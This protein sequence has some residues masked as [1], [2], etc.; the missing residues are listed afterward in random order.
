ATGVVVHFP[1]P[2]GTVYTGGNEWTA[3][4]GSFNPFGN[5][6]WTVGNVPAGDTASITVSYFLLQNNLPDAYAQVIAANETDADSTPGNGTPPSVNEDD[7]ASSLSAPPM[8]LPD[9]RLVNLNIQ[10]SP[11]AQGSILSYSFD[12]GNIGDAPVSGHFN[13]KAWIST[14]TDI[15]PDDVPGEIISTNN[16]PAGHIVTGIAGASAV[17]DSLPAGTYFLILQIDANNEVSESDENNNYVSRNFLVGINQT[18]CFGDIILESQADVDSFS[19]C[20]TIGGNL[21]IQSPFSPGSASSDITDLSPLL[22]LTEVM[23]ALILENN[24]HLFNLHGLENITAIG[25]LAIVNCDSLNSIEALSGL[26]GEVGGITILDNLTLP[27]IDGLNGITAVRR[28]VIITD[29]ASLQNLNGLSGITSVSLNPQH[30]TNINNNPSLTN[31]Q[32]L[33][34]LTNI[35]G[36]LTIVNCTALETLNGLNN[37]ATV[38]ALIL[39]D[40]DSLQDIS[41]LN[42][43]TAIN[44]RLIVRR[45]PLLTDCCIFYDLMVSGGIGT[46]IIFADN[47]GGCNSTADILNTCAPAGDIDLSLALS[48]TDLHPPIYTSTEATLTITNAGP[49]TATGVV[50]HFPKPAGTVYTGGNEWTATQGSFNPFGNEQWTVGN[51]PAGDTAS[52]T[53]SYF[54]LQNDLPDAYAQVIAA[55][56]NDADSTPGNGTPPSVNEDDEASFTGMPP[57]FKPELTLGNLIAPETISAGNSNYFFT[58]NNI[59]NTDVAGSYFIGAFLSAD[60]AIST[61][62]YQLQFI[63]EQNTAV[64]SH[65]RI[66]SINLQANFPSGDYFLIL[67]ADVDDFVDEINEFNNTIS[68]PITIVGP[69]CTGN[70]ILLSQADVDAFP[71]CQV[72]DGLLSIEGS[73]ITDLTPLQSLEEITGRLNIANNLSLTSLHG[74]HNLKKIGLLFIHGNPLLESI[75]SLGNVTD[76][77]LNSLVIEYCPV[78]Q[79][80]HGLEGITGCNDVRFLKNDA[81]HDL[82]GLQNLIICRGNFHLNGHLSLENLNGLD[83]LR[84]IQGDLVINDND[85]LTDLSAL[86]NL[87]TIKGSLSLVNDHLLPSLDGL[88]NLYILNGFNL[89]DNAAIK[90]VDAL[91]NITN[92]NDK[93]LVR[94]NDSLSNCCGLYPLLSNNGVGGFIEIYGNPSGCNNVQDIVASCS[95]HGVDLELAMYALNLNPPIYT[96]TEATLTITN[97]GPQTATGVVVHFPKPAGTV[98]T[99]GNEWTATQGSF[100]PFGNEEWTVGNVPAG[101]TASIT[102]SYF[103]LS[104]NALSAYAQVLL[105]NET[106]SDSAP[107]NGTPPIPNED[108]EAALTLNAFAEGGGVSLQ[109]RELIGRPVQLRAVNPNPVYHTTIGVVIDSREAGRYEL[110]CYDLFGR[111]AFSKK[112]NLE[113]GRNEVPLDVSGLRSGTYYLNMPGENWRGMPLRFVVAR[114]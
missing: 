112:I 100:N 24:D 53:V 82:S 111:L 40:N 47:A 110:E 62:D 22:S 21:R 18:F 105:A 104:E 39:V 57:I 20:T 63:K 59:G 14:D 77:A 94:N 68:T 73:D 71:G 35:G 101:D 64:G 76:G 58:L 37:L 84:E 29:N 97:A 42:N 88:H 70:V 95:S 6:Q 26:S 28:G 106:D 4:Q 54:L 17:P 92:I 33:S 61:D 43:L 93:L 1:K 107:G 3:T 69:T 81:L 65:Q 98:Y 50:V 34:N 99:G 109:A 46:P 78:L 102:V 19:N 9:L 108:D 49:Q 36:Y 96:S 114:W 30:Q 66:G 16:Y 11:V 13:I 32:G 80:L 72:I 5:E 56:E 27:D 45:N 12:A 103:L 2:A 31:I 52:I 55:N 79:S 48:V 41:A 85:A 87:K 113:E 8:F 83:N 38:H 10:N 74:L 51:V 7:E 15:S 75:S 91:S 89:S 44:E 60:N 67:Q 23:G 90:Q 25:S 86:S